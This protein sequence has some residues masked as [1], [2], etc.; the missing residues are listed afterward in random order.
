MKVTVELDVPNNCAEC[1]LCHTFGHYDDNT[2]LSWNTAICS[3][4]KY[5]DEIMGSGVDYN[6]ICKNRAERCP[7]DF[8]Y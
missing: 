3:H 7:F 4:Q 6:K 8:I 1:P 5:H 2:R